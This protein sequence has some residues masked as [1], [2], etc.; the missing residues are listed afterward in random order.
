MKNSFWLGFLAGLVITLPTVFLLFHK[1]DQL[2][3]ISR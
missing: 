2:I 1:V 3:G